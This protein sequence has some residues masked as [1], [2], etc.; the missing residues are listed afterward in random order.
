MASSSTIT[1]LSDLS[2]DAQAF[3]PQALNTPSQQSMYR[4]KQAQ[5][6][7]SQKAAEATAAEK[8]KPPAGQKV[9]VHGTCAHFK[10]VGASK[11]GVSALVEVGHQAGKF[12]KSDYELLGHDVSVA[13]LETVIDKRVAQMAKAHNDRASSQASARID[14]LAA[15]KAR[16]SAHRIAFA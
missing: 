8:A 7:A 12:L 16:G 9:T 3:A 10:A 1:V 13:L 11:A 2:A 4:G 14:L 15:S 6:F 5:K